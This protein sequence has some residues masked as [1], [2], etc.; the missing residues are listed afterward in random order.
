MDPR[1]AR[2]HPVMPKTESAFMDDLTGLVWVDGK[3]MGM[4]DDWVG[5]C[6]YNGFN[7]IQRGLGVV[8]GSLERAI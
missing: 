4:A 5:Y 3:S 6:L 7:D 1:P 8:S 2:I